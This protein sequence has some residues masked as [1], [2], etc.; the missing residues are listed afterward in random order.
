[1]PCLGCG[2]YTAGSDKGTYVSGSGVFY[3][4]TIHIVL[5]CYY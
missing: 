4:H 1:M 2:W 3:D 5:L